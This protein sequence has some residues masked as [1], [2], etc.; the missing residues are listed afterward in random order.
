M[1]KKSTWLIFALCLVLLLSA[2]S[3]SDTP[4]NNSGRDSGVAEPPEVVEL[5]IVALKRPE[6]TKDYNDLEMVQK[7]LE[8]T[9]VKIDWNLVT[10]DGWGEMKNLMFASGDLP[11]ALYG[12]GVLNPQDIVRYGSEGLLIPLEESIEKNAPNLSQVL[13]KRPQYRQ[14][15][16]APDG[17]IY[18]LPVIAESTHR[19]VFDMFF[20]N[21]Q[22]LDELGLE[23]P[24]TTEEYINVLRAFKQKDP[25]RT[26]FTFMFGHPSTYGV[27]SMFGSFGILDSDTHIT[28]LNGKVVF[29]PMQEE[30]K[31]GVQF[32][33]RLYEEGLIDPESFTQ[34]FAVYSS[35]IKSPQQVGSAIFWSNAQMFPD[36]NSPYVAIAPLIGP[37]GHQMWNRQLSDLQSFGGFAITS[38]N[39]YPVETMKW[40][41]R[42]YD[43]DMSIQLSAGPFGKTLELNADGKFKAIPT[44]EGQIYSEWRHQYTPGDNAVNA[45]L[46]EYDDRN[47]ETIAEVQTKLDLIPIYEPYIPDIEDVYPQ[48]L[49]SNEEVEK[50][51]DIQSEIKQYVQQTV[52]NWIV[53]GGIETEWE[54]YLAHL[55][56]VGVDEYVSIF[57]EAYDRTKN[58]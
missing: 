11:D 30:Y 51:A 50:L 55:K 17:H 26:L 53:R 33:R 38:S 43:E 46:R 18:A 27:T 20:I 34:S 41:D 40:I 28:M 14:A 23:V 44:P 16:T 37:E 56:Q 47:L 48:M 52:S 13:E 1:K 29:A 36:E 32:F 3:G 31:A 8:G 6:V 25:K 21:K 22:W 4:P 10:S 9:N 2:C 39:P 57:K 49:M 15:I 7:L 12:V 5:N 42:S 35:K 19:E 58:S 54:G 24:K 45:F